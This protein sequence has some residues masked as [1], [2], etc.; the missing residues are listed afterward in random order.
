MSLEA[1]IK[2]SMVGKFPTLSV[3]ER[4]AKS[5]QTGHQ[6]IIMISKCIGIVFLKLA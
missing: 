2:K 6:E 1:P 4:K 5:K 3:G